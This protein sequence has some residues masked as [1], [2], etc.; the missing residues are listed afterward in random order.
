MV[1]LAVNG[2]LMRG[3]ELSPNMAAAGA[4]FV[5]EAATAPVYR[6]WTIGDRRAHSCAH[7]RERAR[8]NA[9]RAYAHVLHAPG[10]PRCCA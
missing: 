5:E 2:T 4:T 7:M 6:L 8:E 1:L 9:A 10:T 3:L